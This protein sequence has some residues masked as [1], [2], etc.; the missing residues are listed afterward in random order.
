MAKQHFKNGEKITTGF[1]SSSTS[2]ILH[3]TFSNLNL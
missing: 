3:P 2:F 1:V